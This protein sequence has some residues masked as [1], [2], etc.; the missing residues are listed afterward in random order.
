MHFV[1][2]L[3]DTSGRIGTHSHSLWDATVQKRL[4]MFGF[5]KPPMADVL[6]HWIAFVEGFQMPSL[7]FYGAVEDQLKTRQLPGM[8]VSRVEFAEGGI[9]SDK[10]TYLRMTRERLVFD[11]CAAPFGSTFFFSCRFAEI[12]AVVQLWQLVILLAAGLAITVCTWRAFGIITGSL[13]LVVAL[14]ALAYVLRNAI[15]IGLKDVDALLVRS[16][17]FGPV[18]ERFFRKETYYRHDTRLVYL[19][20]VSTIVKKLADDAVAAKGV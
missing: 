7:D 20:I 13:L 5:S 17:L 19:Q 6:D 4:I 10:R 15:A 2:R 3:A 9:L 8:E 18:Y 12:P 1:G 14:I 11:I 16:P